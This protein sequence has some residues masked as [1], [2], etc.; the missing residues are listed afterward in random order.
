MILCVNFFGNKD[1]RAADSQR[2]G[3]GV[4]GTLLVLQKEG[5]PGIIMRWVN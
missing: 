5:D 3:S 4:H 1:K 2:C